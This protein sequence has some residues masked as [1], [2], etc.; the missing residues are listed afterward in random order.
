M[1][2]TS[3]DLQPPNVSARA[4]AEQGQLRI[5]TPPAMGS[6]TFMI[7]DLAR[8]GLTAEDV[9]ASV[10]N[11][12]SSGFVAAPVGYRIPYFDING[13]VHRKMYRERMRDDPKRYSQPSREEIGDDCV[14][15]YFPPGIHA[16]DCTTVAICEGEKKA[17]SVMKHIG[18][19]AIGIG[20]AGNW[21]VASKQNSIHPAILAFLKLRQTR[22][23]V[24]I[25][26]ADVRRY[27]LAKEYGT[28]ATLL[29]AEGYDV[30]L[31]N[32]P[33]K[34]DDLIVAWGDNAR[35][36]FGLLPRVTSLVENARSLAERYGL[37]AKTNAN[38]SVQLEQNLANVLLLLRMHP[39]FPTI[40][41]NADTL[42]IMFDTASI[43]MDHQGVDVL[44]Y[45]QYNLQMPKLTLGTVRMALARRAFDSTR[46]PFREWLE[47]LQWDGTPRL[48]RMFATYCGSPDTD[49]IR[50]VG[51]KWL[52]GAVWRTIE[53]GCPVDYML[54]TRGPQGR[55]KSTL[56]VILWGAPQVVTILG[57]ESQHKDDMAKFHMGK[58][59]SFEEF[60]TMYIS[61]VGHLKGVITNRIDTFRKPYDVDT[62]SHAR[63]CVFYASTNKSIFLKRDDTGYRRFVV[64][65]FEQLQF[66]ALQ[67][68]REQLWAEAVAAYRALES[69][70]RL[71]ELSEVAGATMEAKQYVNEE[72]YISNWED[73]IAAALASTTSYPEQRHNGYLWLKLDH[74]VAAARLDSRRKEDLRALKEHLQETGWVYKEKWERGSF[75]FNGKKVQRLE[76]V[77]IFKLPA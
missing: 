43:H 10:I 33:G 28:F 61:N 50:E 53:P 56:P 1:S 29:K 13:Q 75:V 2:A 71:H 15:P 52:A 58:C 32:P 51:R 24:V 54:I 73:H 20:G 22:N 5:V 64:V 31:R 19:A 14:F 70:G 37:A 46:S 34:I 30:E 68:D 17:A 9:Q 26:D 59:V 12:T 60:D 40:W 41:Y 8:S 36:E 66:V 3:E 55:G 77:W 67:R 44:E 25:P 23:V 62:K 21:R 47:S 42:Q 38:G 76:R 57:K 69:K 65:P 18:I 16:M 4:A 35:G 39:Q 27:D 7:E 48:E 49:F 63:S 6:R 11:T 45:L 74:I 72:D